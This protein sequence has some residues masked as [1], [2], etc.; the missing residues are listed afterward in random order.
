MN[1]SS[2]L[3]ATALLSINT[4]ATDPPL[5]PAADAVVRIA[6]C[7]TLCIDSDHEGNLARVDSALQQA[8]R[9]DADIACFPETS[10]LGWVNP[11]AHQLADPI[12]GPTTRRLQSMARQ[13]Q[14]MI[15]IGLSEK[16]GVQLHDSA[17]LIDRDG[18][19]LLKHRKVNILSE[20]MNP[21]YTP[22]STNQSNVVTTRYGRIGMLVCA[23]TFLDD[24]VAAVA[25]QKPHLLIV[26]YGWAAK[27]EQ[28]PEHGKSLTS[29][30]THTA[31]RV[32]CPVVGVDLIGTITHGPWTG[33]V[34][35]GQSIAAD[36]NGNTIKIAKDR[37]SD[38]VVFA[39]QVNR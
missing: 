20:L 12:P 24:V 8:A 39:V 19:L 7:Q 23:D 35:G 29:W 13:Y 32:G 25:T 30:V 14:I 17:I 1:I 4:N 31:R 34:F 3:L 9:Q 11:E 10:L 6:L 37:D 26:P 15:A 27:P 21:P 2:L 33:Q 36:K 18:T 16:A 38:V 22:G 28:W 5:T